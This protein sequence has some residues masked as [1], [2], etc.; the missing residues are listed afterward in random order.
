M[1]NHLNENDKPAYDGSGFGVAKVTANTHIIDGMDKMTGDEY[2]AALATKVVERARK[3][4]YGLKG[5]AGNRQSLDYMNSLG[6]GQQINHF[7]MKTD[8]TPGDNDVAA[9]AAAY[10]KIISVGTIPQAEE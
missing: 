2:Q 10:E 4:C 7:N 8:G 1:T 9:K 6:G 5:T 3:R